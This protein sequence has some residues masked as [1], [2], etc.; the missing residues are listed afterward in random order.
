MVVNLSKNQVVNL[1]KA[2][3][4]LN[5]VIVGLGWDP[6]G[7]TTRKPCFLGGLFGGHTSVESA[8]IDCDAFCVALN[9]SEAIVDTIY[10][11][12]KT[13]CSGNIVHTGD[14]LT[15]EGDGDDE[16][17]I[18]YLDSMPST[19]KR[20]KIAVNIYCG[21]SRGQS[22]EKLS[23]AF[24]RIVNAE[25]N[26]EMC[27]YKLSGSEYR[28]LVTVVFG[29]LYRDENNDWQFKAIGEGDKAESIAQYTKRFH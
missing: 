3:R 5:K 19:V 7:E 10:F 18:F 17:I 1:S 6:V 8:D 25:N 9:E 14:N 23:N 4:G 27:N 16:Q 20:I 22:F 21:K 26:S 13:G 24:I 15:G 12:N 11:G 29:E 28:G 2:S